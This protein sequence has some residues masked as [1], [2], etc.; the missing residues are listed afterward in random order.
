MA[1]TK[2]ETPAA[3]MR[4]LIREGHGLLKDLRAERREIERLLNGIPAKVDAR[5]EER[6]KAGLEA[7]SET[8]RKTIDAATERVFARFDRLADTLTGTDKAQRR[9]GKRPL[10]QLV[11]EHCDAKGADDA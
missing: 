1:D 11:R 4:E 6:V 8:T 3:E 9:Q 10:E 2:T 7:L 5:I